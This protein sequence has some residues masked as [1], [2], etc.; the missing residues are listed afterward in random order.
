VFGL[1]AAFVDFIAGAD[2][3]KMVK[4]CVLHDVINALAR[5]EMVHPLHIQRLGPQ[6]EPHLIQLLIQVEVLACHDHILLEVVQLLQHVLLEHQD[7]TDP[8][9]FVAHL[10]L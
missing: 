8:L 6:F 3:G 4:G 1:S 7:L 10:S 5:T 2:Q 9:L